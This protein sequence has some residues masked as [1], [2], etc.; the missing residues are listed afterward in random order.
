MNPN[1][2]E[3][4]AQLLATEGVGTLGVD[5]RI[6]S[7]PENQSTIVML[8]EQS[9]ANQDPDMEIRTI[10]IDFWGRN[11]DSAKGHSKMQDIWNRLHRRKA[12]QLT[13]FYVFFGKVIG[14]IDDL[15]KDSNQRQ[16]HKLRIRFTFRVLVAVS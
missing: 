8:V 4:I 12:Y 5:I 10:D 1:F 16:L 7:A 13:D 11:A 14:T 9:G 2:T 6:G 3:Q 15:G